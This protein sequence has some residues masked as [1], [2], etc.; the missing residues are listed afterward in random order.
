[1]EINCI[2][3]SFAQG[4]IDFKAVKS[5]GI[6]SVII[7]A[8][9]GRSAAQKD[10][11]FDANY[12]GA[13][14]AGLN[15]GAYWYSYADGVADIQREARACLEVI[16]G[17]SFNLPVFLDIE[18]NSQ[19]S[20][21]KAT[22]TKMA[23]TFCDII[24]DSGYQSGVYSNLNWFRNY[25]DYDEL[26][27]LYP[28]W[29]AQYNEINSIPCDIWQN[30]STGKINGINGNVDTNII[31]N[32]SII[33]KDNKYGF[34]LNRK[35]FFTINKRVLYKDGSQVRYKDIKSGWLWKGICKP[36]KD[37]FAILKKGEKVVLKDVVKK[38]NR[39]YGYFAHDFMILLK[40]GENT[41]AIQ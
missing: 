13:K 32:K 25:L 15:V 1:M 16:E 39:I 10:N 18:N 11:F 38:G 22:L 14:A 5:A 3:V 28:I 19:I 2:D 24:K 27:K 21:G 34:E 29:L 7:R 36:N 26:K 30:S 41:S 4:S 31:F 23:K 8:G 17:K 35:I 20:L 12:E 6:N 9:Y 40:K 37:G 33:E